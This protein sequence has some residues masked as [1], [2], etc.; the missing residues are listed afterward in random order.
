MLIILREFFN[1]LAPKF[2]KMMTNDVKLV[3]GKYAEK[4]AENNMFE[5]YL[6]SLLN[7]KS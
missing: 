5:K 6:F 3:P 1:K 2:Y 7:L 4:C